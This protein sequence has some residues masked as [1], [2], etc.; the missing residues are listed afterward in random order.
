MNYFDPYKWLAERG[1]AG[2]SQDQQR[3]PAQSL[4]DVQILVAN[5]FPGSSYLGLVENGAPGSFEW[6]RT[7]PLELPTAAD[8]CWVCGSTCEW[9]RNPGVIRCGACFPR[10][11]KRWIG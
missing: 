7:H 6:C 11:S 1:L 2:E 10:P 8:N 4:E 5:T 9:C 3:E